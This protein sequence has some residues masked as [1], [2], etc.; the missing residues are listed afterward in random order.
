MS[1]KE[2]PL[3]ITLPMA[4]KENVLITQLVDEEVCN[5]L[6]AWHDMGEPANP[7]QD[8]LEILR[9]SAQPLVKTERCKNKVSLTLKE[10]AVCYFELKAAPI[11]SD[12][13]YT[14]GRL[15]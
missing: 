4:T 6:K 3:N 15:V 10:N 13:G 8:E 5:P 12:R 11:K 7:S 2:L 1:G 9:A 14:Y